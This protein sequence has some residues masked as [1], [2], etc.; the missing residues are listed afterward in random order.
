MA[1]VPPS[2][3]SPQ[4]SALGENGFTLAALIVILTI[5]SIVIAYTVPQQWSL[6]LKRDRDRHTI[7]LMKQYARGILNWR[8]KHNQT[9]PVSLE[10]LQEARQPRMLRGTGKWPCPITGKEDDWIL[11]PIAAVQ[12]VAP[13]VP[14]NINGGPQRINPVTNPQPVPP[15]A[16][17]PQGSKLNKELSPP[18]YSGPFV[19]VRPNASGKSYIALNGAEDYSEWVFTVDDLVQEISQRQ[20]MIVPPQQ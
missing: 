2:A 5:I 6:I 1:S 17:A 14:P 15:I 9:L 19:A 10:Q 8:T 13:G 18:D 16:N 4:P 12:N 11:V 7:F 3:L 20:A